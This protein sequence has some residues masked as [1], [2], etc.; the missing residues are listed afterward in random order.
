MAQKFKVFGI[1]ATQKSAEPVPNATY[2]R[3][4]AAGTVERR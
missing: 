3:N 4:Y 2:L 1:P